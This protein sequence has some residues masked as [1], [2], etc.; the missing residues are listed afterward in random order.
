MP[1]PPLAL[2]DHCPDV[3]GKSTYGKVNLVCRR[4]VIGNAIE[5]S[6]RREVPL[7]DIDPSSAPTSRA[8]DAKPSP[9]AVQQ[10]QT[11]STASVELTRNPVSA[12]TQAVTAKTAPRTDCTRLRINYSKAVRT[13]DDGIKI[14]CPDVE[15]FRSLNNISWTSKSNFTHEIQADLC[16]QGFPV[17]S[18]HRLCCRDGSPLW[19]VLAVLP[20]TEEA[21]NIFNNLNMVCGLSGIRV[22]APHKKGG[23]GE[24]ICEIWY[25]GYHRW[26]VT[27]VVLGSFFFHP[28]KIRRPI[29]GYADGGLEVHS[30]PLLRQ[31]QPATFLLTYLPALPTAENNHKVASLNSKMDSSD[32]E[33]EKDFY[34]NRLNLSEK[35]SSNGAKKIEETQNILQ[36]LFYREIFGSTSKRSNDR[37]RR[38]FDRIPTRLHFL[39]WIPGNRAKH[40][41]SVPIFDDDS[42]DN[43]VTISI[44]QWKHNPGVLVIYGIAESCSERSYLSIVGV[45]K[46]GCKKC[47]TY[48][49]DGDN[50]PKWGKRCLEHNFAIHT[51]FFCT[52]D[53]SVYEPVVQL[54]YSNQ[55]IIYTDF[56]HIL[57]IDF[58]EPKQEN[59]E[60]NEKDKF[61]DGEDTLN[62]LELNPN[63][64][65][66]DVSAVFQSPK[67][68]NHVVQNILADFS[69]LEA[70]PYQLSQ[71]VQVPDVMG[72]ELCIQA[73]SISY[74]LAEEW[75]GPS[76]TIRNLI[77][78]PLRSPRRRPTE[79]MSRFTETHRKIAEKTYEFVEET[80]TKCEKLSL[81]R[82]RRLADKKYE[83]SEDNNE[84]IVPFRV[85]RSNR[86]YFTGSTSKLVPRRAKSPVT[87]NVVLRAHNQITPQLPYATTSSDV[88]NSEPSVTETE[89]D[90]N[91]ESEYRI[92]EML[93]D[94]SLKTVAVHDNTSKTLSDC[95]VS[96]QDPY[97]VHSEN[98]KCSKFFTRY[99]VESDDEITSI[100]TD[101]EGYHVALHL[102]AHGADYAP[103]QGVSSAAWDRI[104]SNSSSSLPPLTV[105][106]QQ[107]SLDTELLCNELC[108]MW[109]WASDDDTAA[110]CEACKV[111]AAG[112]LEHRRQYAAEV[113]S[114]AADDCCD[115]ITNVMRMSVQW[116]NV[117]QSCNGSNLTSIGRSLKRLTDMDNCIEITKN[118]PDSSESESSPE[119]E[120]DSE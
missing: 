29:S 97:L 74:N 54:A 13:A 81:F 100:I 4:D 88:K 79:S 50:T 66:T 86:K 8:N 37:Y 44:A 42:V 111:G 95:I 63:T 20:R 102:T 1:E 80:E 115:D 49:K 68:Q 16:G 118:H 40:A 112:C 15:T 47:F 6:R 12:S 75:E 87:E 90:H 117:L 26:H 70:E 41:H 28:R 57:E 58:V 62:A 71:P 39:S 65:A 64:P 9:A 106:A 69:D 52:S 2:L 110:Q 61:L 48:S 10:T 21:K 83:F 60:P 94:G 104:C 38:I 5:A 51:K 19:L 99:F 7:M 96:P 113:G 91:S 11:T 14:H 119:E 46:L 17:H 109:M 31:P 77:S 89:F 32:E 36:K 27:M 72:Q 114:G 3:V 84:N 120:S 18:V 85:L 92:T 107:R 34:H 105:R 59:S 35:S 56:I 45:P 24:V 55:I 30:V 93:D 22:E 73:A 33:S 103:M 67:Y 78:P 101:S 43:K 108:A 23:P 25:T 53:S 82:K 98:S 76:P 116:L